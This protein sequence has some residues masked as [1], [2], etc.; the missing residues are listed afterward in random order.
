MTPP[1][2]IERLRRATADDLR[3]ERERL[4]REA[5]RAHRALGGRAVSLPLLMVAAAI[6]GL[7][8][9]LA[10]AGC[11]AAQPAPLRPGRAEVAAVLGQV[12][13]LPEGG[14]R[15]NLTVVN[16]GPD[17]VH[18]APANVVIVTSDG[19]TWI[20][21]DRTARAVPAG[22]GLPVEIDGQLPDG[23]RVE[24]VV[25]AVPGAAPVALRVEPRHRRGVP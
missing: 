14:T 9:V 2:E 7:V 18:V 6:V 12:Y 17:E 21:P 11:G 8:L 25:V 5:R 4:E 1:D 24:S 13:R 15:V 19:A 10:L 3:R 22:T 23:V 16:G 20:S